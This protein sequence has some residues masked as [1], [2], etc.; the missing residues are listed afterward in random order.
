M[1]LALRDIR[2]KLGRFLLTCAGLG[3]LLGVALAMVGIYRGVVEE[4]L[5]LTRALDANLWVVEG[6][7]RGPFAEASRI[8]GDTREAV[9]R[10]AGVTAAGSVTFQTVEARVAGSAAASTAGAFRNEAGRERVGAPLRVQIVGYE[11]DR[12]GGPP[13]LVEGRGIAARRE[14]VLDRGARQPLGAMVEIGGL[15]FRVVGLT[16]R[17]VSSGGDP[18]GWITLADA[19]ELQF[20]LNAPAARRATASGS[21]GQPQDSV[22]A[23]IARL[24][25]HA[26][27][28]QITEQLRRWKHLAALSEAEQ[29]EVLTRSVVERARKQLGLFTGILLLVSGVIVALIVYMLTMDK[30][31]EIAT[32]KLIGAPDRA[33]VSLVMQQAL[34][35]GAVSFASGAA[36]LLLVK[37]VFPRRVV[38]GPEVLLAVAGVVFVICLLA[39]LLGVRAAL[40]IEPAQALGG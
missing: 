16:A 9:A 34:L 21:Q 8:P 33:I 40:R 12:P 37:D 38:L 20:R 23:V 4:A 31:R 22:N 25:P 13:A 30:L 15:R 14:M 36:L 17:A 19:Q 1:N 18:L 2:H 6:G 24:A 10:I 3:L 32:L 29:E 26:D 27:P 5:S 11:L 28:A 39:S 35:L 7:T